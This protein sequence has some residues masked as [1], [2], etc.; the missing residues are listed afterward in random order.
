MGDGHSNALALPPHRLSFGM[1]PAVPRPQ[2]C[3]RTQSGQP[4][5]VSGG[6]R[7]S[8]VWRL[9][10]QHSRNDAVFLFVQETLLVF[11]FHFPCHQSYQYFGYE[12]PSFNKRA[13]PTPK[14]VIICCPTAI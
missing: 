11:S 5:L 8:R 9:D 6:F 1:S 14:V 2:G 7:V 12:L 3:P 13:H 10:L 4:G